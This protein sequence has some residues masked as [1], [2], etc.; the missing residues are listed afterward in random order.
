ME[1]IKKAPSLS[2]K[3]VLNAVVAQ[4][5]TEGWGQP[6][7]TKAAQS[8]GVSIGFINMAF[9]GGIEEMVETYLDA[10]NSS[11]RDKSRKNFRDPMK[12]QEIIVRAILSHFELLAV[13]RGV[14]EKTTAFLMLPTNAILSA[15]CLW[16]T[17]DV[18]WHCVGDQS[19][20]YNYYTKRVL[21]SAVYS[22][23]FLF[24]LHDESQDKNETESFLRRRIAGVTRLGAARAR[25]TSF[26]NFLPNLPKILGKIRYPEH[27]S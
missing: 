2:R 6:A 24:W 9:P 11:M 4:V 21:L 12:T 17:A 20:D 1:T 15:R 27:W 10:I 8:L 26:L 23:T 7:C 16:R 19:T 5:P 18:I 13:H 14:A 25:F 22:S 3:E